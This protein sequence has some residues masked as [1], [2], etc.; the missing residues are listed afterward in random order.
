MFFERSIVARTP[1]CDC[2]PANRVEDNQWVACSDTP[3]RDSSVT[4]NGALPCR[5]SSARLMRLWP[6]RMHPKPVAAKNNLTRNTGT[7]HH[8]GAQHQHGGVEH[9]DNHQD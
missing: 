1:D 6:V 5:H 3:A 9:H 7:L 8:R 4:A 2:A